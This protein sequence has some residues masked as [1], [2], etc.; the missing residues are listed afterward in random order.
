MLSQL[1][2]AKNK[3]LSTTAML[4]V[5]GIGMLGLSACQSAPS[6]PVMQRANST[7]ETTGVGSTKVMA[8]N[9][10]LASA[11]NTCGR[12]QPIVI[13]DEVQYN[14]VLDARTGRMVEQV[15]SI[16]GAVLGKAL[17]NMSREDDYEYM[18][19]FRCQ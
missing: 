7:F 15:G 6:S 10:A 17:P 18:I 4:S 13:K 14:G 11:K 9:Q 2:L 12:R 16:A 1:Y 3:V 5:L 19:S 8:Q